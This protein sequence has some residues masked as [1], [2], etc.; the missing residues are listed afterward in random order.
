MPHLSGR[1]SRVIDQLAE[2]AAIDP[3]AG[4]PPIVVADALSRR[5]DLLQETSGHPAQWERET[6]AACAA[7]LG[8]HA[9]Q[10]G[11]ISISDHIRAA[12]LA[13]PA[14]SARVAAPPADHDGVGGVL[15]RGERLCVP[16]DSSLR[17]RILAECHDAVTGAHLGRDKT[18]AAVKDRFD[19]P[20]LSA[21][22]ERY[23]STCDAC[24]RN[25]PSQQST[26]GLQATRHEPASKGANGSR[27]SWREQAESTPA[28]GTTRSRTSVE[29]GRAQSSSPHRRCLC[30]E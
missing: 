13:D 30:A 27:R 14:Y 6:A 5:S 3:I 25:K 22:V 28:D 8:S 4:A 29:E 26:R 12:A 20:G 7:A 19:W 10:P 9:D 15:W 24:P 21:D 17:T 23:V 16:Q 2:F 1:L 11:A 18:L